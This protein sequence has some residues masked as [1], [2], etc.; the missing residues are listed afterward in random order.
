MGHWQ[1]TTYIYCHKHNKQLKLIKNQLIIQ[2]VLLFISCLD[3][4]PRVLSNLLK[5]L[6]FFS[7]W[8][9]VFR[10]SMHSSAERRSS[11][12]RI[13]WQNRFSLPSQSGMYR[14]LH[15]IF[16]KT[17]S[18]NRV[19]TGPK[20]WIAQPQDLTRNNLWLLYDFPHLLLANVANCQCTSAK[21][22]I[23]D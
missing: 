9:Q 10:I 23:S 7:K 19:C 17:W 1:H 13:R 2:F 16:I 22:I 20:F 21:I 5:L 15:W 18:E 11:H 3:N 6:F 4:K 14:L 12:P 8:S